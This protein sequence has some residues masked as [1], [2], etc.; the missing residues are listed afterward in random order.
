MAR[1]EVRK[2]VHALVEEAGAEI[3]DY[4]RRADHDEL[5]AEVNVL[6]ARRS[7]RVRVASRP[8]APRD[9]VRFAESLAANGDVAGWLVAPL[10]IEGELPVGRA[11]EVIEPEQLIE[12]LER[13]SRVTW[14]DR[15]PS[16]ALDRLA[17]QRALFEDAGQLDPVGLRWLPVVA[18]N[19]LPGELRD[20]DAAPQDWLERLAFRMLTHTF[21]FAGVRYGEAARGKR[22]PDALL[23][24]PS[25]G[26]SLAALLDCKASA[27]GYTMTADHYLRFKE[28]VRIC[29][30]EAEST[31]HDLKYMVVLSSTFSGSGRT[32]PFHARHRALV[33]DTGLSL[34]YVRA[35]DLATAAVSVERQDM[36]PTDRRRLPWR[37]I[38]DA[39]LV[40]PSHF[41][42]LVESVRL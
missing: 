9:V 15:R 31:G 41:R 40:E 10:G 12:R 13:S 2:L 32:H 42:D 6:W 17:H 30:A 24:W 18:H 16:V 11:V 21:R 28:Y 4:R 8:V 26:E 33:A 25:G 5:F 23:R 36:A 20:G 35:I 29:R 19:E 38:F 1:T 37:T 34:A 14:T 22:V 27:D 3:S 39:G 7:I